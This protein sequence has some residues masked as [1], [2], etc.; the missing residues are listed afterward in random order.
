[1]LTPSCWNISA[2]FGG[3]D[4]GRADATAALPSLP[5]TR[6]PWLRRNSSGNRIRPYA[7][8]IDVTGSTST[9]ASA[10]GL[11]REVIVFAQSRDW[12]T[13]LNIKVVA[14]GIHLS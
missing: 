2:G 1:V 8:E 10:P 9:L 7:D 11:M 5:V 13:Y 6:T 12:Q 3:S 14:P 4:T